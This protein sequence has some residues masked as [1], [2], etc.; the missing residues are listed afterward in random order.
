MNIFNGVFNANNV[1]ATIVVAITDYRREGS[2]FTCAGS[3]HKNNQTT[4]GHGQLLD[5]GRQAQFINSRYFG[6]NAPDYQAIFPT[7]HKSAGSKTTQTFGA[8][9]VITFM[10]FLK[11]FLLIFSQSRQY[12]LARL[13]L[14][15]WRVEHRMDFTIN[16]DAGRSARGNE[17]VRCT[18]LHHSS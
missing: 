7:L 1:S 4:L 2:G 14:S 3:S 16:L 18:L 11:I 9:R 13:L 5:N 17:P 12:K 15:K 10:V 6:L 8:H